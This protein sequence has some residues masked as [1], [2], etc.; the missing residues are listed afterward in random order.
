MN[1]FFLKQLPSKSEELIDV[2]LR[3]RNIYSKKK[4]FIRQMNVTLDSNF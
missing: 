4:V 3:P 1:S 2:R